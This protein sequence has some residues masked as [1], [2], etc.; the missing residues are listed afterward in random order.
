MN[1]L[2]KSNKNLQKASTEI[3]SK[4]QKKDLSSRMV[5]KRGSIISTSIKKNNFVKGKKIFR[6]KN[7]VKTNSKNE[8]NNNT[9]DSHKKMTLNK[10]DKE[11]KGDFDLFDDNSTNNLTSTPLNNESFLNNNNCFKRTLIS[12]SSKNINDGISNEIGADNLKIKNYNTNTNDLRK[13]IFI[14]KKIV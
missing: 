11:S 13:K 2:I 6:K 5:I 9:R 8:S 14:V 1:Y 7:I 12:S 10:E 3:P 4:W